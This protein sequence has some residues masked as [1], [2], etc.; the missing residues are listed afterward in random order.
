MKNKR[1][2]DN[3]PK[4]RFVPTLCAIALGIGIVHGINIC[5]TNLI[6]STNIVC[7]TQKFNSVNE[8]IQ[9]MEDEERKINDTSL[10]YC[11]SISIEVLF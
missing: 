4:M 6:D 9:G 5:L 8:A 1:N 2:S 7:E 3:R 10:D 11:P